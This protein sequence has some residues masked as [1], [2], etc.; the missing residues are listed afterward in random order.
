VITTIIGSMITGA[1]ATAFITWALFLFAK[2]STSAESKIRRCV[3]FLE[4][5][6]L[7]LLGGFYV[8][9]AKSGRE[10]KLVLLAIAL[11]IAT[12]VFRGARSLMARRKAH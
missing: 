9:T 7:S 11:M 1:L 4:V 6:M 8:L 5:W 10:R 3:R 2:A 12:L